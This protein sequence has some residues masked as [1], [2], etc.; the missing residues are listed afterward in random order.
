[1]SQPKKPRP[2]RKSQVPAS[3]TPA[4]RAA[5]PSNGD[6]RHAP[7]PPR[8]PAVG[9]TFGADRERAGGGL[10]SRA[11][12]GAR[13]TPDVRPDVVERYRRLIR[14]GRYAPDP[15]A[16]AERLIREGL[17]DLLEK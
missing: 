8:P 9:A 15:E 13:R 11:R 12:A 7:S 17:D 10:F 5:R 2:G 14:E 6:A 3:K 4:T 16:V 1:M